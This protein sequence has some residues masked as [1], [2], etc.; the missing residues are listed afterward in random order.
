MEENQT[1]KKLSF[2]QLLANLQQADDMMASPDL[3]IAELV[4]DTKDKVDAL[5]AVLC[6]LEASAE[7]LDMIAKPLIA[8]ARALRNNHA[9]LTEYIVHS[10][11]A[12]H[13]DC[14]PGNSF[15]V[16]LIRSSIP[17]LK[18]QADA[19][20]EEYQKWEGY[21]QL[22]RQYVW[23]NAKVKESLATGQL[24]SEFPGRLEYSYRPKFTPNIPDNVAKTKGKKA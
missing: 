17:A 23:D 1:E 6:R 9:K 8:K 3:D 12:A 16:A 11:E 14:F 5:H 20:P 15:K 10:M 21:V 19:S 24:P 22:K 2:A 4:G 18:M 13:V 7:Y